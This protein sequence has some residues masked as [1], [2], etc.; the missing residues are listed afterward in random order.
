MSAGIVSR[1]LKPKSDKW[2]IKDDKLLFQTT[3]QYLT[4]SFKKQKSTE[5]LAIVVCCGPNF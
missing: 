1:A 2:N 3:L 4:I 5:Y